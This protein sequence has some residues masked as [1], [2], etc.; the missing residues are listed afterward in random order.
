M[1]LFL[2]LT[3]VFN[4][5]MQSMKQFF[6]FVF[7]TISVFGTWSKVYSQQLQIGL[8][9]QAQVV[10]GTHRTGVGFS[11]NGFLLADYAQLNVGTR[12][13]FWFKQLGGRKNMWEWRNEVGL[14]GIWGKPTMIPN[15]RFSG[16]WHQ[17][18]RPYSLGYAYLWYFDNRSTGQRSGVWNLGLEHLDI[19]FEND[20]F[21]GQAKDRF[22]TGHLSISYKD[23]MY[24]GSIG[25]NTWTGET[26]QSVW[27]KTPREKCPS[28]YRDLSPLPYGKTSHG[29]L[30]VQGGYSI[31]WQQ[32]ATASL[33]FDS[34][35]VRH[36]V[37]NRFTHDLILLPKNVKR[38]T[39][40]Y[41]R[42]NEE[43]LPVFSKS[44]MRKTRLYLEGGLNAWQAY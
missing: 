29:I 36:V 39:P 17:S 40:H 25:V 10:F 16:V 13:M 27:D 38:N 42:L 35:Q 11:T 30:F 8:G 2:S 37:Q 7:F 32:F 3:R 4:Y 22:R 34:E 44:E 1:E 5:P 28:G 9:V 20:V 6:F 12:G 14:V 43:G 41:P 19:L 18:T 33:G 21:G 24:F 15:Q 23:S 31:G 26:R